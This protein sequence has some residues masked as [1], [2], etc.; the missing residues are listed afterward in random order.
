[1]F[2][3]VLFVCV[4]CHFWGTGTKCSRNGEPG[5]W[6]STTSAS[7]IADTHTHSVS[8]VVS[9]IVGIKETGTRRVFTFGEMVKLIVGDEC[10]LVKLV[11]LERETVQKWHSQSRSNGIRCLAWSGNPASLHGA[12]ST[13]SAALACGIVRTWDAS[14]TERTHDTRDAPTDAVHL[15][16]VGR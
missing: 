12:E 2:S 8:T 14:T 1:M 15:A 7:T 11:R 10:G 5:D 13:V 16:T 9:L 3:T 6:R 4:C